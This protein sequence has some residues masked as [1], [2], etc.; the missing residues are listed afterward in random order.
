MTNNTKDLDTDFMIRNLV[1]SF[2]NDEIG[3]GTYD[4][5]VSSK[6]HTFL[7]VL[8]RDVGV[9]PESMRC[10]NRSIKSEMIN[11]LSKLKSDENP[12]ESFYGRID[13]V[14]SNLKERDIEEYVVAF[15]LNFCLETGNFDTMSAFD[16][17]FCRIDNEDWEDNY[18]PDYEGIDPKDVLRITDDGSSEPDH[19]KAMLL[20][21]AKSVKES[22]NA[23]TQP[24]YTYWKA[25][26]WAREALYAL[27]Y[28]WNAIENVLSRI[29]FAYFYSRVNETFGYQGVWPNRWADLREPYIAF[30]YKNGDLVKH[31]TSRDPTL[32]ERFVIEERKS[33]RFTEI[34]SDIP[35]FQEGENVDE[36]MIDSLSHFQSGITN[37]EY[38]D[39]F[40]DFWRAIEVLV[41]TNREDTTSDV[42]HRAQSHLKWPEPKVEE[43]RTKILRNQRNEH[44]HEGLAESATVHD[45]NSLKIIFESMFTFYMSKRTEWSKSDFDLVLS[46]GDASVE[47]LKE[48]VSERERQVEV[49]NEFLEMHTDHD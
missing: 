36:N 17:T 18:I 46:K 3:D 6:F 11:L 35:D 4:S 40:F 45:R 14:K 8:M 2:K 23:L 27:N 31:G 41:Q 42:M 33:E 13:E 43:Q 28:I 12:V 34:F 25:S 19:Q 5:R 16:T 44:V 20:E 49:L 47:A 39:A 21:V 48:S 32:R 38:T 1:E 30:I 29:N 37:P 7:P 9:T 22:P 24:Y 10:T 26:C 15:P